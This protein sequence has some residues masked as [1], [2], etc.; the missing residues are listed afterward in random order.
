[1]KLLSYKNKKESHVGFLIDDYVI[2]IPVEA[3]DGA[4]AMRTLLSGGPEL[5]KKK[6]QKAEGI[7]KRRDGLIPFSDIEV[8]SLVPDPTKILCV[9]F[10][11][12]DHVT[13]M[14]VDIPA[15]P[16]I[17]AKF[18]NALCPD[19]GEIVIPTASHE[20][21]YEGELVVVIGRHCSR[22]SRD[23][24]LD[25]VVGYTMGNDVSARD[26]QFQTTQYTLGKSVDTFAPV[27]PVMKL[28]DEVPDPRVLRVTTRLNGKVMQDETVDKMVYSIPHIIESIS[29]VITLEPGDLI[30]TG[31]PAGVGWKQDPICFMKPGDTV[32]VEV[33]GIGRL[34]NVIVSEK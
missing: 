23:D 26:L 12:L 28:S 16:N 5:L 25:Y 11:Y 9:G 32:E 7:F 2:P 20:I 31:T 34:K 15:E 14:L 29:S 21:D 1:M 27:G 6:R 17:F 3:T 13:E 4:S 8:D 10:N 24:A 19:G 18:N 30:F 33:S 22:V